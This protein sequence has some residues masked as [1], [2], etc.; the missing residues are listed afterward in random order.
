M[1]KFK[2]FMLQAQKQKKCP[3]GYRFDKKYELILSESLKYVDKI[4]VIS[5]DVERELKTFSFPSEKIVNIPRQITQIGRSADTYYIKSSEG[6]FSSR[7]GLLTWNLVDE[8]PLW[9]APLTVPGE[10]KESVLVAFRGQGLP[11]ERVVLDLHSGRIFGNWGSYVMDA[12][13]I[14]LFIL[15]LSGFYKWYIRR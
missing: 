6:I 1:Y 5:N 13:A 2:Q 9:V 14:I 7:D 15:V 10:I 12:A 3:P 4:F 8:E 11:W